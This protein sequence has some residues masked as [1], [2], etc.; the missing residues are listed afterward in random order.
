MLKS[1]KITIDDF[2]ILKIIGRGSYSYVAVARKK[3]SGRMYAIKIMKKQKLFE[4]VSK[5][6]FA[7][8]S[9]INKKFRGTPFV[10]ETYYAFQ[11]EA[12]MFLVMELWPGG[13]LFD[14]LKKIPRDTLNYDI[15]RFYIAEIVMAL[16]FVHAKNVMYRDLKPENI[17]I[18]IGKLLNRTLHKSF[19]I[20]LSK[21]KDMKNY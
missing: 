14:Y 17:I 9:D 13:T 8:E 11:T 19:M 15:V 2:K 4:K 6:V 12:E 3:D 7:N 1:D 10:A 16:E 21:T 5:T 20:S 18:D